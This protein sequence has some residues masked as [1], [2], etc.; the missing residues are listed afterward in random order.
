[1]ATINER[2]NTVA[3]DLKAMHLLL[4]LMPNSVQGKS[5]V[6]ADDYAVKGT[7]QDLIT[8]M[9]AHVA[10]FIPSSTDIL[11]LNQ[12]PSGAMVRDMSGVVGYGSCVDIGFAYDPV[13]GNRN[14]PNYAAA[15][16]LNL[17]VLPTSDKVL[18]PMSGDTA[19]SYC[20]NGASLEYSLPNGITANDR[21]EGKEGGY[22]SAV[23]NVALKSGTLYP[24]LLKHGDDNTSSIPYIAFVSGTRLAFYLHLSMDGL[25]WHTIELSADCI[26]YMSEGPEMTLEECQRDIIKFVHIIPD[27]RI[28]LHGATKTAEMLVCIS[29][30]SNMA[31]RDVYALHQIPDAW[32]YIH[33]ANS[34]PSVVRVKNE[35]YVRMAMDEVYGKIYAW[36]EGGSETPIQIGYDH[37]YIAKNANDKYLNGFE[38]LRCDIVSD[39]DSQSEA[40]YNTQ[41]CAMSMKREGEPTD[42]TDFIFY[43]LGKCITF[44]QPSAMEDGYD[45]DI[46]ANT[47]VTNYD[48]L[49]LPMAS[50]LSDTTSYG[51][52][53]IVGTDPINCNGK[54]GIM[55]GDSGAL[56]RN[57][58]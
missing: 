45:I 32:R 23:M 17:T 33:P 51:A 53:V 15:K 34:V 39:K 4:E 18:L 2:L 12:I 55:T 16:K 14:D 37:G 6:P 44:T 56:Y 58:L 25:T 28:F 27:G 19:L 7:V 57:Q 48:G 36:F 11:P 30:I 52:A 26:G 40:V 1:M 13:L 20:I 21:L 41:E 10:A 3:N 5:R 49:I 47:K 8:Q 46:S 43:H 50:H 42:L 9:N 22:H 29:T 24:V 38:S 31:A 35:N 54:P